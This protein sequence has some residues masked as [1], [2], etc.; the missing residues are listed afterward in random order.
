[1]NRFISITILLICLAASAFAQNQI[2]VS[3]TN[4]N[5]YSQGA[6]TVFLTYGNLG[7]YVPAETLWC[8]DIQSASPA[9]GFNCVPGTI[10]GTLPRRFDVSRRSPSP[11]PARY[12][13]TSASTL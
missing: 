13:R 7:D 5:V 8:G 9:I 3:P 12:V 1:M 11:T 6:T 4:V 10:Y 2:K